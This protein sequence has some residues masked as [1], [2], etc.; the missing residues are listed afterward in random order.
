MRTIETDNTISFSKN[1]TVGDSMFK[2][3]EIKETFIKK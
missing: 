2:T 1:R 3:E